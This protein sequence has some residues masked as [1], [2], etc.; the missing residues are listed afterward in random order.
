M[1]RQHPLVLRV[2]LGEFG[3]DMKLAPVRHHLRAAAD[4]VDRDF[5]AAGD[6]KDGFQLGFEEASVT[7]LGT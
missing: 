7:G 6:G 2:N 4:G 5:A 1:T 3:W